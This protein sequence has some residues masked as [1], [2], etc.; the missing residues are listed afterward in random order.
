MGT[1]TVSTSS[2]ELSIVSPVYQGE[3]LVHALV[4]QIA[5]YAAGVTED[6]EIILVDDGSPDGSWREIEKHCKRDSR[7]KGI[8]LSRNF[9]QHYALTAGLDAANGRYVIVLDCDLQD[10][11]KYIPVLYEKALEGYDVVFTRKNRRAHGGKRNVFGRAFHRILNFLVN[12]PTVRSDSVIGNYSLLTRPVVD[13]FLR[14]NDYYRHYLGLLRWLGFE[15]TSI[16]I[17]HYERPEGRSSYTFA[18]LVHEAIIGI[19]SQSQRLLRLTII[20]GFTFVGLSIVAILG[21]VVAY[22]IDGFA[23]G[24]TSV[25]VLNLATTGVILVCIGVTG[26]Y[27]GKTFDQTKNRPLYVVRTTLNLQRDPEAVP[28]DRLPVP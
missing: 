5:L 7:V 14:M 19:T 12:E 17:E 28:A 20:G 15:S 4:E 10:H 18:K 11:P 9:G 3:T 24:W 16:E 27:V 8:Q 26:I 13:A 6:F 23:E 21:L 1:G 25:V 22:L 2:I